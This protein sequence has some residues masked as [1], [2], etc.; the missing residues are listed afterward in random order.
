[1]KPLRVTLVIFSLA[2]ACLAQDMS[3]MTTYALVFLKKGANWTPGSTPELERLQQGHLAHLTRMTK[4]GKM[5]LAGPFTDGQDPLGICL[6][7]VPLEEAR[8]LAEAD[9]SVKAGRLAV[10]VRP[11]MSVKGITAPDWTK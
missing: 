3:R 10:E 5:L 8:S 7:M 11:W 4:E 6:Y 2:A 9:P 1:M